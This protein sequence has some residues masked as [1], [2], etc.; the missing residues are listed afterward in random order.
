MSDNLDVV[1][2]DYSDLNNYYHMHLQGYWSSV[3]IDYTVDIQ[4]RNVHQKSNE[5]KIVLAALEKVLT[6]FSFGDGLVGD[7]LVTNL[8][9]NF[10]DP[11]IISYLMFQIK[12]ENIHNIG[13]ND[14]RLA[15]FPETTFNFQ[16]FIENNPAIKLKK[17]WVEEVIDSGSPQECLIAFIAVEA[18]LFC[19]SFAYIY[20]LKKKGWFPGTTLLNEYIAREES[21]HAMIEIWIANHLKNPLPQ[22]RIVEIIMGAYPVEVAYVGDLFRQPIGDINTENMTQYVQYSVDNILSHLH[23]P[24]QFNVTNPYSFMTMMNCE[25]K[26]NFFEKRVSEYKHAGLWGVEMAKK[27]L[28]S[29]AIMKNH[30]VHMEDF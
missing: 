13:Y 1:I 17:K 3:S 7:N 19:V 8:I 29:S 15:L 20:Y 5:G 14:A 24:S 10:K 23:C 18:I 26:T 6:W 4:H 25:G 11:R 27:A 22:K 9:K 12:I 30:L 28:T 21:I 16:D 2:S